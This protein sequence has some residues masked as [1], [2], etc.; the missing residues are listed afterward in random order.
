MIQCALFLKKIILLITIYIQNM[1]FY[2]PTNNQWN[3]NSN[4]ISLLSIDLLMIWLSSCFD[5]HVSYMNAL[6]SWY[7]LNWHFILMYYEAGI[8][9]MFLIQLN[10]SFCTV[11]TCFNIISVQLFILKDNFVY[12]VFKLFFFFGVFSIL[13]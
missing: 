12:N 11:K 2:L 8:Q 6:S 7:K 4:M 13:L 1:F 9:Y 5:Y 10:C 3:M